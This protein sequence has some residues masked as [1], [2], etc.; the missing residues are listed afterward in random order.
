M[1][2]LSREKRIS[3]HRRLRL[4]RT[5]NEDRRFRKVSKRVTIIRD[6]TRDI[7]LGNVR[8]TYIQDIN[9]NLKH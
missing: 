9:A 2:H 4:R 5:R 1:F 7:V 3:Y 8:E 6:S